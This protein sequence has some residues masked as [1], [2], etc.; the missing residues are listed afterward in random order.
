[1]RQSVAAAERVAGVDVREAWV[2]V[3][4]SHLRAFHPKPHQSKK[5]MAAIRRGHRSATPT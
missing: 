3:A 4:G 5:R 1:V 2:G